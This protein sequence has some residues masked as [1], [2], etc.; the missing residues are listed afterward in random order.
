SEGR[1][2]KC[3][4][5]KEGILLGGLTGID[6]E[7]V[8]WDKGLQRRRSLWIWRRPSKGNLLI[9]PI[10]SSFRLIIFGAGHIGRYLA[11]IGH[12]LEFEVLIYDDREEFLDPKA[13]P[14]DTLLVKGPFSGTLRDLKIEEGDFI[15]IA[16]RGHLNDMWALEQVLRTSPAYV[17]M[18]GS[19]RKREQIFGY[20]KEKGFKE[21][22]LSQVHSPIG[23]EIGAETPQEIAVS[24]MAEIIQ[25][26]SRLFS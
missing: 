6:L 19:K 9:E 4:I 8:L 3:L 18:I 11:Q 20:L 24:I 23:L 25:V 13:F 17:G 5:S 12:M 10:R 1:F 7:E 22:T 14:P 26:K 2:P 15:T 21:E 16:T